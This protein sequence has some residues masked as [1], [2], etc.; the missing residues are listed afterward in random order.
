MRRTA[1]S[2]IFLLALSAPSTIAHAAQFET[3]GFTPGEVTYTWEAFGG[4]TVTSVG[5]A[6]RLQSTGSG[7]FIAKNISFASSPDT[8]TLF[9]QSQTPQDIMFLWHRKSEGAEAER[10]HF[11]VTLEAGIDVVETPLLLH[12]E[13]AW[14]A[15]DTDEIGIFLPPGSDFVLRKMEFADWSFADRIGTMIASALDFQEYNPHSINFIWG[16]QLAFSPLQKSMMWNSLPPQSVSGTFVLNILLLVLL[17]AILILIRKRRHSQAAFKRYAFFLFLGAWVLFDLRMGSEFL[18]WVAHDMK[19]YVF[20]EHGTRTLRDRDDF[21]EF[22]EFVTPLVADRERYVFFAQREWPFVGSMRYFTFP[23]LPDGEE[24][25]DTWVIYD[26]PDIVVSASSQLM[27]EGTVLT[28]PG[29]LLGRFSDDS[30]VFRI[31]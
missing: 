19:T 23:S 11:P 12:T 22:T 4:L 15:N 8:M 18:G 30:F 29:E 5:D 13:N 25:E 1:L 7:L 21:Y 24:T 3:V 17:V 2:A 6:L 26:R 31:R 14:Q 9:T 28:P 27:V 16:P 10:Y 20:A